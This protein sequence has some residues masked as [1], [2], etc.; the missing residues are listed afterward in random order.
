MKKILFAAFLL[1]F[2]SCTSQDC[3]NLPQ[4]FNSYSS[5]TKQVK[6]ATFKIKESANTSGSSWIQ[7][8]NFYSC[9]GVKGY[10]IFKAQGKE[11]IHAGV[12]VDVWIGFKNAGSKGGYYNRNI[13]GQFKV[14]IK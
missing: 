2:V 4:S 10:F 13:K 7:S 12:P 8:A 9:D 3:K 11:Y 6:S 14:L 1:T 5:A